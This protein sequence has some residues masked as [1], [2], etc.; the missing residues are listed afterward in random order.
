[1]IPQCCSGY[2]KSEQEHPSEQVRAPT[3]PDTQPVSFFR[4]NSG[5]YSGSQFVNGVKIV[6]VLGFDPIGAFIG[7]M[8][9]V[10]YPSDFCGWLREGF[11]LRVRQRFGGQ[12]LL[13]SLDQRFQ[14][15]RN[16]RFGLHR[17]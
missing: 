8:H 7:G 15:V 6:G 16:W 5:N 12:Q 1:M 17:K 4:L 10:R 2:E 14:I 3:E 9:Q 13:G 11:F